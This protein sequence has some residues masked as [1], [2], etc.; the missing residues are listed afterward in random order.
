MRFEFA[1]ATRIYFGAGVF[2]NVGKLAAGMGK[3]ALVV[4]LEPEWLDQVQPRP[5]DGGETHR[6]AGVGR[7][8][9][10]EEDDV[11]HGQRISKSRSSR[12]SISRSPS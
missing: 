4:H 10:M 6:I 8:L 9:G 11:E 5:G 7:D 12:S 1:T 2:E 3:R